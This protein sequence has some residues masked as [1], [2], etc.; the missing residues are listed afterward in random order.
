MTDKKA[1]TDFTEIC[2]KCRHRKRCKAPCAPVESLLQQGNSTPFEVVVGD[3]ILVMR[4]YHRKEV[5]ESEMVY[6]HDIV[7]T[8]TNE[9]QRAFST[10]NSSPFANYKPKLNMTGVFIDRFFFRMSYEDLA[11][12]Y[13]ATAK[14]VRQLYFNSKTRI[15]DA[16][17]R[18]DRLTYARQHL[19]ELQNY[20]RPEQAW[21]LYKALKLTV[22]EVAEVMGVSR[23]CVN[24]HLKKAAAERQELN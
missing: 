22:P 18:M 20:T 10:A 11:K 8:P 6:L 9:A 17:K 19:H 15:I 23:S 4:P 3:D 13:D 24:N 14:K 16:V 1:T 21:I 2:K 7:E 5:R 12:K